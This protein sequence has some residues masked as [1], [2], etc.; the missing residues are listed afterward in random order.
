MPSGKIISA[1][2]FDGTI[3]CRDTF[4]DFAIFAVGRKRWLESLLRC[5]PV[6]AGWKLGMVKAEKAKQRLF[7]ALYEGMPSE[8]FH[9]LGRKYAFRINTLLRPSVVAKLREAAGR[10]DEVAIVSASVGDW[11]RPWAGSMGVDYVLATEAEIGPDGR[12]TGR[13][14]TRNCNGAEKVKR[15]L[16][17]FPDRKNAILVAYG[18]SRG[19]A[20]MLKEAD[21]PHYV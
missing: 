19:D 15:L 1:F 10:G 5:T 18:D 3:T 7:S 20:R 21:Y 13:F 14:S 2:D 8:E 6:L 9:A 17:T 4:S 16:E 11:I 12:L